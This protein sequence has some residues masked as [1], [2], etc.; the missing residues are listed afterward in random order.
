MGL[1][2]RW[3]IEKEEVIAKHGAVAAT[4]PA[5]ADAG[6]EMLKDGG[7]AV[8]AAV[9][10]GFLVSVMEPME[11]CTGGCGFMLVY[12][13]ASG[14]TES[15]EFGPRAPAAARPDMYEIAGN[16]A[17]PSSLTIYGVKDDANAVGYLAPGIPATVAG[18]V[19]AHRRFGRLPLSRVL[20]PAIHCAEHGFEADYYYTHKAAGVTRELNMFPRSAETFLI[21][22][23]PPGEAGD[24]GH[25][26][27]PQRALAETLRQIARDGGDSFYRGEIA[28]AM[29]G[30]I[31]EGGGILALEDLATYHPDI[32]TAMSRPY[33]GVDVHVPTAPGGHWTE[34]QMLALMNQFELGKTGHNTPETL[35]TLIEASRLAFTDRYYHMGDPAFEPV[36][37]G[38]LLSDGYARE[39]AG[40]IDPGAPTIP[41][42]HG[43]PGRATRSSLPTTPG[44]MIPPASPR[45][46]SVSRPRSRVAVPPTSARRTGTG[47]SCHALTRRPIPLAPSFLPSRVSTCMLE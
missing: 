28:D 11:T 23:L 26:L 21:D 5:Q 7:S 37:L 14:K 32:V 45:R 35:H 15:I 6:L 20:E 33:R 47:C 29:V 3:L 17:D 44:S 36:P 10:V 24:T 42:I 4:R 2:T 9:A 40:R 41:T 16:D 31:R 18:L 39:T 43:S 30:E 34:L 46:S 12:D 13:P 22:G 25:R 38:A 27:M 19:E 8:D 1:R